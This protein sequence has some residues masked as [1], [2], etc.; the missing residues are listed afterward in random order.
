M[1]SKK[2][3]LGNLLIAVYAIFALSATVRGL[4]QIYRK[5]DDAPVAYSLSLLAGIVYIFATVA[6]VRGNFRIAKLT[7]SFELAGV[8]VVGLLSVFAPATFAHPTVW[9]LFGMGYGFIPL[10]LPI[11]GLLWLRKSHK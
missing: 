9:S 3:G 11:L 1:G 2:F 7:I 6:L 5:F 10:V 4:Y 8:V